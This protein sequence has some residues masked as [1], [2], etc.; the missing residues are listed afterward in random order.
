MTAM[1]LVA[2]ATRPGH[3]LVTRGTGVIH[4]YTG[5]LTPSH[6]YVPRSRSTVCNA[7]TR[8]LNVCDPLPVARA[9]TTR[10]LRPCVRCT[11]C[12][13]SGQARQA[14]PTRAEALATW[15]H[16]TASQVLVLVHLAGT[17]T[18]VEWVTWVA[19]LVLGAAAF[20]STTPSP[21]GRAH[22]ALRHL[23]ALAR[24]RVGVNADVE[25]A[26]RAAQAETA[27]AAMELQDARRREDWA[28]RE[29]A[30]ER[31]GISIA[32]PYRPK[33]NTNQ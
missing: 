29:A 23:I 17:P 13:A 11:A 21:D 20:R 12:L 3:H 33:R 18:E 7:R 27:V 22:P 25:A 32:Q 14:T 19:V 26:E 6:R 9:F 8:R 30:I 24:R 28:A 10:S 5:P 4:L 16:L 31:F 15:G 2:A 1:A